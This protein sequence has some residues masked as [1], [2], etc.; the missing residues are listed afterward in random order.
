MKY[1]TAEYLLNQLVTEYHI[2]IVIF[3]K[4]KKIVYPQNL[5][6][7]L[8]DLNVQ[9]LNHYQS[10]KITLIKEYQKIYSVFGINIEHNENIVLIGP[11]Y[12]VELNIG[13]Y[14][15]ES[16]INKSILKENKNL[17]ISFTNLS[18]FIFA[19]G[20]DRVPTQEIEIRKTIAYEIT[21]FD[22]LFKKN[23][24]SRIISDIENDS[25]E[26][27]RRV[28]QAII[29]NDKEE[30]DWLFNKVSTTYFARL[31][32]NRLISLKYK[33]IGLITILTRVSVNNGV[34]LKKTYGLSD[35]LIQSLESI[36][37]LQDC[38][39]YFKESC[40]QFMKLI[41]VSKYGGNDLIRSAKEYIEAHVNQKI[42]VEQL[43][44][45]LRVSN[46][47][48]SSE[49]KKNIGITIHAYIL[50]N[51]IERARRLLVET[52][53]EISSIAQNLAFTDQ[54]HFNR[55][56]K[57]IE[58]MTPKEYRKKYRSTRIL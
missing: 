23:L 27:E 19:L 47:Y 41:N 8:G 13:E 50:K 48:L 54:S 20:N 58:N 5:E 31:H 25:M 12:G 24:E 16:T 22:E 34:P 15:E 29:N 7:D 39:V 35:T 30:F 6:N 52:D 42:T 56:F 38:I 33:Y 2:P 17:E 21:P 28:I 26:I 3:D 10:D 55:V 51:K 46:S 11:Q 49:F 9:L 36:H 45:Y 32:S 44:E 43:A 4:R 37:S 1:R 40:L 18:K 53:I 14:I 57:R